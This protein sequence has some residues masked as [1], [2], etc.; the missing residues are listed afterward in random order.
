MKRLKQLEEENQR[1]K[2]K[3]VPDLSLTRGCCRTSSAEKYEAC[4]EATD[5]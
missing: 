4:P 3:L 2:K 1:L 5:G